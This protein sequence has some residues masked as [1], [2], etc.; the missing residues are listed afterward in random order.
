MTT[1]LTPRRSRHWKRVT[2]GVLAVL[3]LYLVVAWALVTGVLYIVGSVELHDVF[4]H[5]WLL[6]LSGVLSVALAIVLAVDPRDGIL[7]LTLVVGIY[8]IIGGVSELV[9]AFRLH[10]VQ[11]DVSAAG[12]RL[13]RSA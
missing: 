2:I 4:P 5:A 11:D 3:L 8:A 13:A 1:P 12:S 10:G 6:T 9:F 7:S